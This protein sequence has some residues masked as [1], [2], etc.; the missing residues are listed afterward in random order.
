MTDLRRVRADDHR[1]VSAAADDPSALVVAFL[2]E[3]LKL[4]ESDDFLVRRVEV[5]TLGSPPTA[6]VA[7]VE[8][9]TFDPRRHTSR[10]EVKAVTLH[11]L[12]FDVPAGR[13]RVIVDI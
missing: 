4:H 6:L 12:V 2:T 9:E 5:R 8:G 7:D 3:L 10:T 13:A 1:A 11:R